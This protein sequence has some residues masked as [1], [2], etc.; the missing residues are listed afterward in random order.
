M[1]ELVISS[2]DETEHQSGIHVEV[3][4]DSQSGQNGG[5]HVLCIIEQQDGSEAV[6]IELT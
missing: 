1:A 3:D 4:Q 5:A 2:E 6:V